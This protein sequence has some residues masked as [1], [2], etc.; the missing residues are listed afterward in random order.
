M[1]VPVV[2]IEIP[3][4]MQTEYAYSSSELDSPYRKLTR[5]GSIHSAHSNSSFLTINTFPGETKSVTW[6]NLLSEVESSI[7]GLE[8]RGYVR[9]VRKVLSSI[10]QVLLASG[11]LH[12][13]SEALQH[14]DLSEQL[15]KVVGEA[16]WLVVTC[17][18]AESIWPPNDIINKLRSQSKLLLNSV[19]RFADLARDHR[20][21]LHPVPATEGGSIYQQTNCSSESIFRKEIDLQGASYSEEEFIHQLDLF[22]EVIIS[23][24]SKVAK[25]ANRLSLDAHYTG[26]LVD[27]IYQTVD[28]IGQLLSL[29][30]SMNVPA[31]EDPT[32]LDIPSSILE[33]HR[34]FLEKKE[35][36]YSDVNQLV[37][38]ARSLLVD[39]VRGNANAPMTVYVMRVLVSSEELVMA[40]KRLLCEKEFVAQISLLDAE[41][42][43]SE[44][45]LL[46]RRAISLKN[47]SGEDLSSGCEGEEGHRPKHEKA[48]EYG[49]NTIGRNSTRSSSFSS[50]SSVWS[51]HTNEDSSTGKSEAHKY[52]QY[53]SVD[54][55][56]YM[57]PRRRAP[58][59]EDPKPTYMQGGVGRDNRLFRLGNFSAQTIHVCES[60]T[61]IEP[62][63]SFPSRPM[64]QAGQQK[65]RKQS[66]FDFRRP[67]ASSA[68]PP[69][70]IS[71]KLSFSLGFNSN[72]RPSLPVTS[73]LSSNNGE[74][75]Q[76]KLGFFRKRSIFDLSGKSDPSP[77]VNGGKS[78]EWY[79]G[80]DYTD[81]E[82]VFNNEGQLIGGTIQA[83]V[84]R[85]TLHDTSIDSDFV[86]VFLL[87]FRN[88]CCPSNF[89]QLLLARFKLRPPQGLTGTQLKVWNERKLTPIR[90]RVHNILKT[91]LE[92]YFYEDEDRECLGP[93]LHLAQNDMKNIMPIPA[94][95][96]VKLIKEK[97]DLMKKM[98]KFSVNTGSLRLKN[99]K[100][101]GRLKAAAAAQVPDEPPPITLLMKSTFDRLS[102]QQYI[103]LVDI[104]PTEVARQLTIMENELFCSIRPHELIGQEFSKK[105]E[106]LSFN[107]RQ[108]SKMSTKIT[109]WV[110]YSII[111]EDNIRLR[112]DLLRYFIR[113]AEK[114]YSLNNF[115]TLLAIMCGLNLSTVSRLK[116]TWSLLPSK[117]EM[118]IDTL[119]HTTDHN[120][121]YYEYRRHIKQASLPCLPFMGVYLTD[122]TFMDD[123]NPSFRRTDLQVI[124]FSKH[125]KTVRIIQEIQRF[126]VP[127]NLTSVPTLQTYLRQQIDASSGWNPEELYELS[128][129]RE[130]RKEA[131]PNRAG[132][133]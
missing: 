82:T 34:V 125:V 50:T 25:S 92:S 107:V 80:Y 3:R 100:S 9:Q 94:E 115:Q 37:A 75:P 10:R 12:W 110:V 57:G 129:Q 36:M 38:G 54:N 95:R 119:R 30:E 76:K 121:N 90:L 102:A 120:R 79:L 69:A 78:H 72:R 40:T 97:M 103:P 52:S 49:D 116:R 23:K 128:L 93:I 73:V 2:A 83:L 60:P 118:L 87:T 20:V 27:Q 106:S 131:L 101:V 81:E 63:S 8:N 109:E 31:P 113:L 7:N 132:S 22:A 85:L 133:A 6:E 44:L 17:K 58:S 123:G 13:S 99:S 33:L 105:E 59:E 11:T 19:H 35:N 77:E 130:P 29:I 122:L 16:N 48:G 127:Y 66:V 61:S 96:L 47:L 104:E 46:K 1:S 70:T 112:L 28:A 117:Y 42:S 64:T 56:T 45:V 88:F 24:V 124:N 126:Q 21:S 67:P 62:S 111:K 15:H 55:L 26:E 41:K 14:Q 89:Y 74:K 39:F 84:E 53:S 108:M 68:Q 114:C 65:P 98:E 86:N 32:L 4:E 91:W 18:L 43:E 5:C 51:T 71:S